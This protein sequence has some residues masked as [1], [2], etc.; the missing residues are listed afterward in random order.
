MINLRYFGFLLLVCFY[1]IQFS[2]DS[3]ETNSNSYVAFSKIG[4]LKNFVQELEKN[5]EYYEYKMFDSD[6]YHYIDDSNYKIL[7]SQL[8]DSNSYVYHQ[9]FKLLKAKDIVKIRISEIDCIRF[10]IAPDYENNIFKSSWDELFIIYDSGKC[11][12]LQRP[13]SDVKISRLSDHWY[14]V[15]AKKERYIKG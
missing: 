13:R 7:F 1:L 5:R 4:I 9:I 11:D 6:Q 3:H 14:K 8:K 10:K 2:C 12:C 15:I